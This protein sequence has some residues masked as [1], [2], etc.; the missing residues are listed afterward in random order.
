MQPTLTIRLMAYHATLRGR[1]PAGSIAVVLSVFLVLSLLLPATTLAQSA[2]AAAFSWKAH[3]DADLQFSEFFAQNHTI[4]MR[5]MPQFPHAYEGP[6]L[7]EN[8]T[9]RFAI[10]QGL[11]QK[12]NNTTKLLLAVGSKSKLSAPVLHPGQWYHLAVVATTINSNRRFTV[13]LDG[14]YRGALE[15]PITDPYMPQGTV[16]LGKRT[17]GKTLGQHNAQFYGLLDD[18]AVFTRALSGTEVRQ[19]RDHVFQL[20]GNESGLLAGYT[21]NQGTLPTRLSRPI[22]RHGGAYFVPVS[23]D[24]DSAADA[25]RL[26]LPTEHVEMTL[27]FRPGKSWRVIQGYDDPQGSHYGYAAFCWDLSLANKPQNGVYPDGSDGAPLYAAAPGE[28]VTVN[29]HGVSGEGNA[30]NLLEIQQAP[31]EIAGY[32]HLR[33]D[34]ATV[35]VGNKA[36]RGQKL[37]LMGDTG[38]PVGAHHLHLP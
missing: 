26:P 14:L 8:G 7:A 20:T 36:V 34:S 19:L 24:R 13:Y 27:P 23:T 16:R 3:I 17:T 29:D 12:A 18:V 37:A 38:V 5:F 33:Q 35:A 30:A 9:G 22:S 1:S 11:Y 28:V 6:F 32:L 25:L 2:R 15:V 31:E 10:G 21:F 4:V